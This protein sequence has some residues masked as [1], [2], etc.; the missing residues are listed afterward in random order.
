M[1]E[2]S[3]QSV[4]I[5]RIFLLVLWII[6]AM[7]IFRADDPYALKVIFLLLPMFFIRHAD[8]TV[9]WIDVTV[10]LLWLYNL[11]GCLTGINP[12]QTIHSIEGS[13]LCLLGYFAVRQFL[14]CE[15]NLY[16]L[17][18]G[19][20]LLI[21]LAVL[22]AI[23][24]FF[25]FRH[26]VKLA[27]FE[28]LHSFRFLFNPLG[29][30]INSWS[31]VLIAVLGIILVTYY[32][33]RASRI[34]RRLLCLFFAITASSILLSFSRGAYVSLAIYFILLLF[35]MR[36]NMYKWRILGFT[37]LLGG[38][39]CYFF[40]KDV[41][42]TILMNTTISQQQSSK[43]RI[44]ASKIALD[45]FQKHMICGVG[46]GNYTLAVDKSLNQDSTKG[47][48]SYA[49]SIIVLW[50]IEKGI[51]GI[52]IYLFLAFCIGRIMWK[53]RKNDMVIIAGC[54]LFAIY[55]KEMSLATITTIPIGTFLCVLLLAIIQQ[56][57]NIATKVCQ[58]KSRKLGYSSLIFVS[59]IYIIFLVSTLQHS[60][61][62]HYRKDS[63]LA[64]QK[65]DYIEAVRL[66]EQTEKKVPYLICRAIIYIKCF[67]QVHD[68]VYL[69]K[70]ESFLADAR[71]RMPEDV[72]IEYL[73]T[74]LWKLKGEENKAYSKL[75][76][77][78]AA[79]P[80]NALYHK[81]LFHLLYDRNQKAKAILHLEKAVRLAP[82]ILNMKSMKHISQVD[83]AFYQSLK[84]S[85]L[86]ND[87]CMVPTDFARYGY[88]L[89]HL[90]KKT[91][92][93]Q[94]LKK[95]IS[96]L[97]NLSTP[98]LLLGEIKRMQHK[99]AEAELCMKRFCLLT[100]GA[101]RSSL[102]ADNKNTIK[103]ADDYDLIKNY[104]LKFQEWYLSTINIVSL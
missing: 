27:G 56:P 86:K 39:V 23:L 79:Y 48:T 77:L 66:I 73:Q 69:N 8:I 43:G 88:I 41:Q 15:K 93:E 83:G 31:T 72:C 61:S 42:T 3:K 68:S 52:L 36:S 4:L 33:C 102:S 32:L 103:D 65:G 21:G 35:C 97:P 96:I 71:R 26:S 76:E 12:L 85:L 10:S 67:I 28:E 84:V 44:Q 45:V 51:I 49:P 1:E 19:V 100:N 18:K 104:V 22:L 34:T 59:I 64:Y 98:W 74:K 38:I 54:T 14:K 55:V 13:I 24:S 78:V 82:S 20:C 37:L 5:Q 92:A 62:E 2:V 99:E 17:L 101:F 87:E 6:I 57:N 7:L 81:D 90:G 63:E 94:Y 46:K 53:L 11:T 29:Y 60:C 89:Y 30:T 47:Y 9:S 40:Q 25:V 75:N 80:K 50:A 58:V 95:S 70:A 91:K 16:I